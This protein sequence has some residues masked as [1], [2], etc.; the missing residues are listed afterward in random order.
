QVPAD[1]A[2]SAAVS[3]VF[4]DLTA[5]FALVSKRSV[6][7][8]DYMDFAYQVRFRKP[9]DCDDL[10]ARLEGIDGMKGLV[11]VNEQ[12]TVEV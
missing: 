3:Q 10:L 1:P 9:Q 7:Q 8:G 2:A 12:T 6:A 11:Y 5:H 4:R